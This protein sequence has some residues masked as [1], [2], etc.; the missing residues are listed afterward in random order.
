MTRRG[1]AIP[2]VTLATAVLLAAL[3]LAG[4][5]VA[6]PLDLGLDALGSLGDGGGLSGRIIQGIVLLT[7]LSVAPGLLIMVTCF[8]RIIVVL[9]LLRSALGLQQSPPNMVLIS[10][11]MFLTFHIMGPT[12]DSA[13]QDGL[14]PLLNEQVTHEQGLERMI[15]PFRGFMTAH[16]RERDLAAFASF[17]AR[18]AKPGE[19][20]KEAPAKP[21]TAET[22]E[23]RLLMPAFLL[24]ELRRAFEIGFLLFLPF[25]VI[26]MVVAAILM[27][28]GMMMLPPVMIALPFKIIFFVLTDGWFLIAGSLIRSYGAG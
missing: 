26:D 9:S 22:V 28:M 6:A 27:A 23:L 11:A 10:L 16:V 17:S 3:A 21:V 14:R 19:E 4:P 2:A 12:I 24:S 13:W 8:T 25:L 5:A 18:P 20:T 7:V 15:E 1:A